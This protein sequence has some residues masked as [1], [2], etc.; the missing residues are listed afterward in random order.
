MSS[1]DRLTGLARLAFV[2]TAR[3]FVLCLVIQLFLVGLDV[4]EVI[5]REDGIHREFAYVYGWLAPLLVLLA[6]LGGVPRRQLG[7]AAL[8]LVLFAIQTYLPSLAKDLPLLA[9]VH[10]V[11]ALAVFWLA[12]TLARTSATPV[13]H[14]S[15]SG[16]T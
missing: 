16:G 11:N 15:S 4:F 13:E 10:A 9:A 14:H 3:V 6:R 5:A 8:L 2:A 12:L 7:L 1:G